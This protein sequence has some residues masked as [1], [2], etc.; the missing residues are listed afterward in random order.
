MVCIT[1]AQWFYIH[2]A[3]HIKVIYMKSYICTYTYQRHT[4]FRYSICIYTHMCTILNITCLRSCN[5]CIDHITPPMY[6]LRDQT[7]WEHSAHS[8]QIIAP[9][10]HTHT[11]RL[12]RFHYNQQ[13]FRTSITLM[14]WFT[15]AHAIQGV[16]MY[17]DLERK[18]AR[19]SVC[20]RSGGSG[21]TDVFGNSRKL[22]QAHNVR[23]HR[24]HD[25]LLH[26]QC[27]FPGF[28]RAH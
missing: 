18:S 10:H 16:W 4:L 20:S 27:S 3:E 9:T 14:Q 25:C 24:A 22:H 28:P 1:F 13:K 21:K 12:Q 2:C 17:A 8:S 7:N 23:V 6:T 19:C 11:I 15:A 5:K 26:S